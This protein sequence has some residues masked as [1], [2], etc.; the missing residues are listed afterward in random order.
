MKKIGL[1][2]A[3]AAASFILQSSSL[4]QKQEGLDWI[5]KI[6]RTYSSLSSYYIEAISI[7]DEQQDE[8]RELTENPVVL[9]QAQP[10][11]RRLELKSPFMG[12]SV[13]SDGR[14]TWHY[15]AQG[16]QY[17]KGPASEDSK[18][19]NPFLPQNYVEQYAKLAGEVD[20]ARLA[21]NDTISFEGKAV[22]CAVVEYIVKAS[23][24]KATDTKAPPQWHK[25]WIDKSRFLVLQ[26]SW[27]EPP[28]DFMGIEMKSSRRIIFK[29]IRINEP[30]P[31][32]VFSFVP[33]KNALEVEEV[34]PPGGSRTK[35][36]GKDAPGL[37]LAIV[38]GTKTDIKDLR[39]KTLL[40]YVW[41]TLCVP[42][43]DT[44]AIVKKV[45]SQFKEKGLVVLAVNCG[46]EKKVVTGYLAKNHAAGTVLLRR[47]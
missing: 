23:G 2:G 45:D 19:Q 25:L 14:I 27:S 7:N 37:A 24:P 40:L 41:A 10:G 35:T 33:P 44:S 8:S 30:V 1:I 36:L 38:D 11:K 28:M 13:V 21:G 39:G 15:M 12:A 22:E 18:E 26:E 5:N 29:T 6:S 31:D 16:H 47:K 4:A 43:R 42:C 9:A 46:E 34:I 17:S 32:S 3:L 20:V